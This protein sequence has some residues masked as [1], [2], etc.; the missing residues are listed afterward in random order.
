LELKNEKQKGSGFKLNHKKEGGDNHCVVR[1]GEAG[2]DFPAFSKQPPKNPNSA[3]RATEPKCSFTSE[4][5][6]SASVRLY[7][8]CLGRKP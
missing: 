5:K 4:T 6:G 2:N 1:K 8:F 3:L 7:R